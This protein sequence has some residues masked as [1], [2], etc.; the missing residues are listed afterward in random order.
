MTP[1]GLAPPPQDLELPHPAPAES[2]AEARPIIPAHSRRALPQRLVGP[3]LWISFGA[4]ILVLAALLLYVQVGPETTPVRRPG[5]Q[6]IQYVDLVTADQVTPTELSPQAAPETPATATETT[7]PAAAVPPT[8][9]LPQ[10]I[11]SQGGERTVPAGAGVDGDGGGVAERLRPGFSDPRLYVDPQ[12][13]RLRAP[14]SSDI[15]RYRQHF[16]ARIDALND[17]LYGASGP[18]TDW[19][20]KDGSGNRWGISEEGVHLGP[21]KIPRALVPFPAASGT[22]QDLEEAREQRRQKEEIDRQEAD[23]E[24]RRALEESNAAAR[25]RRAREGGEGGDP[26]G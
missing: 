9:G 4:H 13:A 1:I 15:A 20:V 12:A 25:D 24:R 6:T 10:V 26:D 19:T 5:Q 7:P 18:N 17:S 23:R 2:G 11:T 3:P 8:G 14:G 22:N 21:L 16:Q